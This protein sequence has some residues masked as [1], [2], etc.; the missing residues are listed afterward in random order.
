MVNL[1]CPFVQ[2]M[3]FD[4]MEF[5]YA[6]RRGLLELKR[7]RDL[8]LKVKTN[9]ESQGLSMANHIFVP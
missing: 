8:L 2:V 4:D 5:F 1:L 9:I 7:K 6:F 3:I